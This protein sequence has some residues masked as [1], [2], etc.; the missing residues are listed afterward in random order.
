MWVISIKN[1]STIARSIRLTNCS[2]YYSNIYI[3][4]RLTEILRLEN[5]DGYF[6]SSIDNTH[7]SRKDSNT[8]YRN[9]STTFIRITCTVSVRKFLIHNF[10]RIKSRLIVIF[11]STP[12]ILPYPSFL[13]QSAF[14][15]LLLVH[16]IHFFFAFF[17]KIKQNQPIVFDR[18]SAG[19]LLLV[20]C[21]SI[22]VAFLFFSCSCER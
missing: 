16:I 13:P 15:L 4:L 2:S 6:N 18:T 21:K 17:R 1:S 12:F 10:Y 22:F 20:G 5:M 14:L 3:R 19:F 8:S 9:K 7:L 11:F